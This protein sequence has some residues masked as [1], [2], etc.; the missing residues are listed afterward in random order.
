VTSRTRPCD[1]ALIEGRRRKAEQFLGAAQTVREFADDEADVGDAF[2]T[3]CVHAGVAAADVLC[4]RALG[5]HVQGDDHRAAVEE[6]AK[7]GA[8]HARDLRVLLGMKTRAGY[9]SMPVSAE[10]RRRAARAAERLVAAIR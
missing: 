9:S 3:L 4:C 10:Q 2:V 8:R 1:A 5:H 7:V 6:V